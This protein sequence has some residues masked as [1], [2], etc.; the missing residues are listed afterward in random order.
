MLRVALVLSILAGCLALAACERV[1]DADQARLCRSII[2]A[3]N[4]AGTAISII[5]TDAQAEGKVVRVVYRAEP[6]GQPGRTRF[7][8]CQFSGEGLARNR[9]ELE[10]VSTEAGP[11][12]VASVYF[13]RRFYLSSSE[14]LEDPG[15]IQ[16][17][18]GLPEVPYWAAYGMQQ[19][20]GALPQAAVYGLVAAAYSLV[21]GLVGRIVFGFGELASLGGYGALLGVT[22]ALQIGAVS[23][24]AGLA[25][26]FSLALYAAALHG[27]V[28]GRL[29]VAPLV[30]RSGLPVL[31]ATVGLMLALSEYQRLLQG[32]ELR[33]VPPVLNNPL[34]FMRSGSFVST[35]TPAALLV[36][37][38]SL[39][40]GSALVAL[41][42]LSSFGRAWRALADDP[43]T[44]ALFGV[45]PRRI[46]LWTF[47]LS[48][49]LAGLSGFIVTAYYGGVGYGYGL[50]L[51]LK[52]LVAAV[53][54]GIGSVGGG[55]AGG[56][57]IG[58]A[59]ALWSA[60]MPIERRDIAIYALLSVTLALRPGGLLG[61][62]D[63]LP[64]RI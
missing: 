7:V 20:A 56:V 19:L 59:E 36:S 9:Q 3:I 58:L 24:L 40:A 51:G 53:I 54:G 2:P 46:F 57:I 13:L 47:A 44:A 17:A 55:L 32:N 64:R 29:V 21:Y 25:L 42:R 8:A 37:G 52:A 26:A 10:S 33:W 6:P 30:G 14:A 60:T 48:S 35:V 41:L 1:V 38:V 15:G 45:N 27:A 62:R 50:P 4:P 12:S 16:S 18:T 49:A 11:M 39:L 61:W 5:R 43:G 22:L 63:L 34:P 28:A 23:P 31:I